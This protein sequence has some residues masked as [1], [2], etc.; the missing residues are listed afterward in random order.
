MTLTNHTHEAIIE[1]KTPVMV[2]IV[3]VKVNNAISYKAISC[4]RKPVLC[5]Q[6]LVTVI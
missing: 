4:G 3:G 1:N 6:I 5:P 2:V